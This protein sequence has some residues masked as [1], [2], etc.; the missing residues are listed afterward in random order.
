MLAIFYIIVLRTE[1]DTTFGSKMVKQFPNEIQNI[2]NLQTS[3]GYIFRILQ[4]FAAKFWN[5]NTFKRFF[6]V[7]STFCLYH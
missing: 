6:P 2:E 5:F 7:I 4:L 1:I 3:Q